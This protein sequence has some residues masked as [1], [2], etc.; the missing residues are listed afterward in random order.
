MN[1]NDLRKHLNVF[2]F[3]RPLVDEM[4]RYG[5]VQEVR[6]GRVLVYQKEWI[7]GVSLLLGGGIN[8]IQYLSDESSVKAGTL[9]PGQ[10][11][12]IV[13]V[14][15]SVPALTDLVASEK[16]TILMFSPADFPRLMEVKGTKDY[17]LKIFA[18]EN[19]RLH[20][21]MGSN[22]PRARIVRLLV[23]SIGP[24]GSS[25]IH[26]TQDC[27]ANDAGTT[28]ETTNR[29]LKELERMRILSLGRGLITIEDIQALESLDN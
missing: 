3:P 22:S 28:R 11:G 29:F 19:A 13:E 20:R 6:S 15:T 27:I 16:S 2:N 23:D 17:F 18:R 12:G 21:R 9:G 1:R 4:I 7:Q 8:K 26:M 25:V 24:E 14:L 10:W 5:H